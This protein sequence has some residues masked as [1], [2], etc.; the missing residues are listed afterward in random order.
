[1]RTTA[2]TLA[3][4]AAGI[5]T[6]T[7]PAAAYTF[8]TPAIPAR[9]IAAAVT[10]FVF[11]DSDD[12]VTPEEVNE[13]AVQQSTWEIAT[14]VSKGRDTFVEEIKHEYGIGESVD[15][16]QTSHGAAMWSAVETSIA[17][18]RIDDD[19]ETA[20][21][22]DARAALNQYAATSTWNNIDRWN[23]FWTAVSS[24]VGKSI[25]G[26]GVVTPANGSFTALE[27]SS[28]SAIDTAEVEPIVEANGKTYVWADYLDG[29]NVDL[30]SWLDLTAVANDDDSVEASDL[31][32]TR[33]VVDGSVVDILDPATSGKINAVHP[34]YGTKTLADAGLYATL[35]D[36]TRTLRND[37]SADL[38]T[39]VS[40]IYQQFDIGEKS[41]SDI[42][43]AQG[44]LQE[45]DAGDGELSEQSAV[46][47][48]VARGYA[49][50]SDLETPVTV[51][52]P[53]LE[54]ETT[55]WLFVD[56]SSKLVL[57]SGSTVSS[58]DYEMAYIVF[59][60]KVDGSTQTQMLSGENDLEIVEYTGGDS[61]ALEYEFE[62]TDASN[63]FVYILE[64]HELLGPDSDAAVYVTGENGS[65]AFDYSNLNTD[66]GTTPSGADAVY[67]FSTK[68][69]TIGA[70]E[71]VE[72][73]E[74][75][76][77]ESRSTSYV[78]DP[79][80]PTETNTR[81]DRMLEAWREIREQL[82]TLG[83]GGGSGEDI[84]GA[85]TLALIAGGLGAIWIL[86]GGGGG[87]GVDVDL[88]GFGGGN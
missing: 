37:L 70:V 15:T 49:L 2:G 81:V 58:S 28:Q 76:V 48:L 22:T 77:I 55:G 53:D 63:D 56:T 87:G 23:S 12:D 7:R 46:A 4:G 73:L 85:G 25:T 24:A 52:H 8:T 29:P 45:F 59:E 71:Q 10:G 6:Q 41:P 32:V 40:A 19:S 43:S 26:E 11:G 14:S 44:M 80:N 66:P 35:V 68:S 83:G 69:D 57:T 65:R 72:V 42:I 21:E 18:S 88:S 5:G 74:G 36:T 62:R 34:D 3:V 33:Y 9:E 30:P 31:Y 64:D 54:G 84:L 50:P 17:R 86:F 61:Y 60:S 20:A 79:T 1:M 67:S 51:N 82:D 39:T 16:L 78:S 47:A 13:T 38:A 75:L 27:D